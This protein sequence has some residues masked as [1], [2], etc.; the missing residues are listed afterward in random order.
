MPQWN[1]LKATVKKN[2]EYSYIKVKGYEDSQDGEKINV[3][4]QRGY[5]IG[6]FPTIIVTINGKPITYDGERTA[7][8][9]L[10]FIKSKNGISQNGGDKYELKYYKYKAKYIKAKNSEL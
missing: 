4:R 1:I 3:L 8:A 7:E 10:E 9:I 2:P 6:G 5:Q